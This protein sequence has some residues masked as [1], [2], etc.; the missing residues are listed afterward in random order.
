VCQERQYAV[1]RPSMLDAVNRALL[2]PSWAIAGRLRPIN[3][4]TASSRRDWRGPGAARA[5]SARAAQ[6]HRVA[7]AAEQLDRPNTAMLLEIPTRLWEHVTQRHVAADWEFKALT[8]LERAT[9]EADSIPALRKAWRKRNAPSTRL[10]I[11]FRRPRSA[12]VSRW[13]PGPRMRRGRTSGL[14]R[15][16]RPS[17]ANASGKGS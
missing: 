6:H 7:E 3:R 9:A 15:R 1:A 10:T 13:K 11:T 5:S 16:S 2:R 14:S 12:C 17:L 4:M 8:A